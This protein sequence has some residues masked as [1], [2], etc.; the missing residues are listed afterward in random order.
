MKRLRP[1]V[2]TAAVL[3]LARPALAG[4]PLLCFPFQIGDA[5]SLPMGHGDWHAVDPKYDVSHL[6]DDT[7]ALLTPGAPVVVRMETLRRA[8]LYAAPNPPVANA[9]LTALERR[10]SSAHEGVGLNVF[11]FGYLVETYKEAKYLFKV[12]I[13]RLDAI[14]GYQMVLKARQLQG[15]AAIDTAAKQ[16]A[17]GYPNAT[18]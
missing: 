17:L 18:R 1:L 8:T 13:A 15:D 16:I 6:V 7:L 2:L 14:D 3:L 11:D 5:R 4:P 10:A 12:P 9:L